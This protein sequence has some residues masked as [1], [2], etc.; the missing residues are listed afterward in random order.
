M[1]ACGDANFRINGVPP[2]YDG[3]LFFVRAKK[4]DEK[5]ARPS[6]RRAARGPFRVL[7]KPGR[8]LT[9]TQTLNYKTI[10]CL[11]C[12]GQELALILVFLRYSARAD[13]VKTSL[14]RC[15]AIFQRRL[16]GILEKGFLLNK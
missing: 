13:G 5:K 10:E 4:R 7:E 9:R 2:P 8:S 3:S 15:S 14:F 12:L 1:I 16:V 11:G 6:P